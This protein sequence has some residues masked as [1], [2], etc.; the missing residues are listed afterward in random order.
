MKK[1]RKLNLEI[2]R[3]ALPNIISNVSVPLLSTVDTALM[4]RL[5]AAH[6][7]AVGIS[8]MIFNF[9]YWNFGFLRMGTTGMTAQAYGAENRKNMLLVLWRSLSLGMLISV[10]LFLFRHILMDWSLL[11]FQVDESQV[12]FVREYFY[13][14]IWAAPA[15]MGLLCLL[16]WFFGM[17]NAV[18]P[19]VITIV[20]NG[21][22]MLLSYYFVY[23]LEYG[24]RGVALGTLIAQYLGLLLSLVFFLAR[25]RFIIVPI[26]WTSFLKWDEFKEFLLTNQ[27]LFIRTVLLTFVFAFFYSQSSYFGVISLAISVVIMQF[28]NW[29][30]Y[31]ID[32][33]AFAAE[34]VVGKYKGA[35]DNQNLKM[36][37]RYLM[38][39]GMGFAV[40]YS[41][42]Y[43]MGADVLVKV[44]SSDTEVIDG[45]GDYFFWLIIIPILAF[46]SYIWDGVFIG[47]TA[48]K[49]MRNAMILPFALF[50]AVFYMFREALGLHALMLAL[51]LFLLARGLIQT[52]MYRQKGTD[53][54]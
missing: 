21:V 16:G 7:G 19:L 11:A 34:S 9:L 14:R 53:L 1:S 10:V 46:P 35:A 50:L 32:G 49:S 42:I 2:W 45:F 48:S 22:N 15:Y 4:G 39:W 43:G 38:F 18:L 52:W 3:L 24:I 28:V 26:S 12:D 23:Q 25:Y 29:M 17:Q 41:A 5:S 37:I 47:L 54:M 44:F 51:S 27:D 33:I 30:S 13:I 36:A 31:G 40:I 20:I 8:A 6:L